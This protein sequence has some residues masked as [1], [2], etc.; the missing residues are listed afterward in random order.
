MY[1]EP[2][3]NI[4]LLHNVPIDNSYEH[5]LYFASQ[6]EQVNYFSGMTKYTLP[7]NTYQRVQRGI[8][9]VGLKADSIYDCNYMMFQNTNYG[10]KW[11]YAFIN[12]VEFVNNVTAE[13]QFEIDVIQTWWFDMTME[14]CLVEREHVNDDTIG[15]NLL[16]EPVSLGEYVFN[17]YKE[18]DHDFSYMAVVIGVVNIKKK[19]G[20]TDAEKDL[21][22]VKKWLED[23]LTEN[24][25]VSDGNRYD[26]VYSGAKLY[27]YD[28]TDV[29][30]INDFIGQ[31][32]DAP[33][34]VVC[35]YVC[36]TVLI[37]GKTDID[38][39]GVTIDYGASGFGKY[40][41]LP[42]IT[43]STD[44]GGYHPYRP[45]N[46]KLYTYPYNFYHIDNSNG[47]ELNL[48]Y[49]FFDNLT[50]VVAINGTLSQPV[51]LMLRP[52]SYKG[53]TKYTELGGYHSLKTETLTIDNYPMCSW[54]TDAFKAWLAQSCVPISIG[55][56][57]SLGTGSGAITAGGVTSALQ[58]TY[59][60]SIAADIMKGNFNNGGAN[61]AHGEQNFYGGRCSVSEEYA[62]YIDDFFDRYGYCVNTLKIP[63]VAIRPSYTYVKTNGFTAKGSVPADD[64]KKIASV[65]NNGCTFWKNHSEVGNYELSNKATSET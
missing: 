3:T 41:T 65:F 62:R 49:E 35:M 1:I 31:F 21:P 33:D 58:Q 42:Q 44:I 61:V 7:Q 12:N 2:N 38:K 32:A 63:D 9:R 50:P 14:Q 64:M 20:L 24:V 60:A 27:A 23:K 43:T 16:P 34:S 36:P 47:S 15:E 8:A 39:G 30:G 10:N 46:N 4:R 37:N 40:I 19:S 52:C 29:D 54:N 57:G 11:F 17:D 25:V 22:N 6:T 45:R 56:L 59:S 53:M 26:G 18:I 55:L 13:I 51:Q 48:R 5:E 28:S